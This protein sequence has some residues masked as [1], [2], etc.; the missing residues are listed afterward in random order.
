M[1]NKLDWTDNT[2]AKYKKGQSRLHLLRKLRSFGVQ[3]ALMTSFYDSVVASAFF[4]GGVCWSISISAAD[5]KRLDK[6]INKASSI[7]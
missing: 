5:R 2:A 6:L 1:N 4:Y 3:G 7:L